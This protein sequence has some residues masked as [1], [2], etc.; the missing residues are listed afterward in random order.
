MAAALHA[1]LPPP[2][3]PP[4]PLRM[5]A[6]K[7]SLQPR[8]KAGCSPTHPAVFMNKQSLDP[9]PS[10][11]SLGPPLPAREESVPAPRHLLC[12]KIKIKIK[13]ETP[14]FDSL[15]CESCCSPLLPSCRVLELLVFLKRKPLA[16]FH[17]LNMHARSQSTRHLQSSPWLAPPLRKEKAP[18]L[19]KKMLDFPP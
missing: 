17:C 19:F 6:W 3:P 2:P 10:F 14:I 9:L 13:K 1:C 16:P 4:P 18:L 7:E 8:Q 12:K 11:S 15:P 5:A